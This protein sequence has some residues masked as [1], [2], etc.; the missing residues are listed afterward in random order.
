[1]PGTAA[2]QAVTET[3]RTLLDGAVDVDGVQFTTRPPATARL[4]GN[5]A[6]VNIFLYRVSP[7]PS[8]RNLDLPTREAEGYNGAFS[9]PLNLH[10]LFVV[11]GNEDDER[12]AHRVLGELARF[13]H[14]NPTLSAADLAAI[15]PEPR[16]HE[17]IQRIHITQNDLSLDD[18]SRL[19]TMLQTPYRLSVAYEVRAVVIEAERPAVVPLP[20]ARR[21]IGVGA[22]P[23]QAG[24]GAHLPRLLSIV[25]PNGQAAARLGDA[26][27][28]LGLRF[29]G[30]TITLRFASP[31]L[32]S[33]LAFTIAPEARSPS[34][35]DFVIPDDDAAHAAWVA[36]TLRV[37][38]EAAHPGGR[39]FAGNEVPMP[40]APRITP[41]NATITRGADGSAT[42]EIGIAPRLR[43]GQEAALLLGGRLVPIESLPA[44]G[45]DSLA[46]E[47][48]DAPVGDSHLRLRVDGVDSLVINP[49][50]DPPA[51]DPAVR[52]SIQ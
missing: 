12:S 35:I 46:V 22:S 42:V 29:A 18:L 16:L 36:G 2:I 3:L 9:L 52:V 45:A 48:P 28:L 8:M 51:F 43:A 26:I 37:S 50:A 31:R 44:T 40:L 49:T 32:A 4:N 19:W 21:N 20:V 5:P 33:P 15:A 23:A 11:Y 25:L 17:Q 1:M 7:N 34:R 24:Q 27:T 6:Q 14:D 39:V 13:L 41:A 30:E 38:V 10:Y 47:V